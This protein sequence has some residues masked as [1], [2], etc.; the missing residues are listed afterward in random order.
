MAYPQGMLW[1]GG[2]P[3]ASLMIQGVYADISPQDHWD[4]LYGLEYQALTSTTKMDYKEVEIMKITNQ[5]LGIK[6]KIAIFR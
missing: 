2:E 6:D 5:T 3:I 1:K 4:I